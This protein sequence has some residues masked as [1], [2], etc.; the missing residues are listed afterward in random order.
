M[1]I[2]GGAE[3]EQLNMV[4]VLVIVVLLVMYCC[5]MF[6]KNTESMGMPT[7]VDFRPETTAWMTS[8]YPP[9]HPFAAGYWRIHEARTN[10]GH[11]L[12][13]HVKD[14]DNMWVRKN[15]PKWLWMQ[16]STVDGPSFR[17]NRQDKYDHLKMEA[18]LMHTIPYF[19]SDL[20][21][22]YVPANWVGR[23]DGKD[24]SDLE[25][26]LADESNFLRA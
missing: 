5:G 7:I 8:V 12:K 16:K 21:H 19:S 13:M 2:F 24:P 18:M 9:N 17:P 20:R 23:T 3:N 22:F 10:Q 1:K 25:A 4:L 15:V 11:I 14:E 26:F 6:E